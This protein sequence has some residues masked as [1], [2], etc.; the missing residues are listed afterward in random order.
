M[1]KLETFTWD[2]STV[3][4]RMENQ[5]MFGLQA[6]MPGSSPRCFPRVCTEF[7][8]FL[9]FLWNHHSMSL[10]DHTIGYQLTETRMEE[11]FLSEIGLSR[12]YICHKSKSYLETMCYVQFWG[13]WASHDT[14]FKSKQWF[15][16][17]TQAIW[18]QHLV[19]TRATWFS[20]M[21]CWQK[22]EDD[23]CIF[24]F[25]WKKN[26]P[27]GRLRPRRISDMGNWLQDFWAHRSLSSGTDHLLHL[28]LSSSGHRCHKLAKSRIW[29]RCFRSHIYI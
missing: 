23:N 9:G 26:T 6:S 4:L 20:L 8:R 13:S 5:F 27:Q 11:R 21:S 12:R 25:T 16:Y 18:K 28:S 3:Q 24:G 1:H 10:A 7:I 17:V 19:L 15:R 22:F 14:D 29:K 2:A